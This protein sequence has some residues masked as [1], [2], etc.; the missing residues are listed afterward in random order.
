MAGSEF[1]SI[2]DLKEGFNQVKNEEDT[3]LKMAVLAASG[4]YLP[5]GLTFGPT[6]GPEDFQELVFTV[7][8]RH[9]YKSWFL[10]LDDLT[11]ATG[12]PKCLKEGPSQAHDV[13]EGLNAVKN[14]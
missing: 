10:F 4:C 5:Q 8:G 14:K 3:A 9:L 12:R 13:V 2:C 1:I 6:N 11:V 7:F